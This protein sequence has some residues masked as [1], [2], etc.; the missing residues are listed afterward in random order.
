MKNLLSI[1]VLFLFACAQAKPP[2][3]RLAQLVGLLLVA[4]CA[5]LS[6]ASC[7]RPKSTSV[8]QQVGSLPII[9]MHLHAHRLADYGGG[10]P[11]CAN[12]QEILYA[13]VDPREPTAPASSPQ[14][15]TCASPV[16]APSNDDA[17]MRQTLAL[18]ERYNIFA[19]TTGS[20]DRVRAWHA[21]SPDR[22]IPAHAFADPGSEGVGEFRGLLRNHELAV[23][24]EV[25]PQYLGLS[26]DDPSLEPYFALAEEFDIPIG[27]HLG[28]GPYGGPYGPFPKYR[29]RLTS[30]FQVEDVLTRHPKLRLYVM[31][32]GSPLVD[33]M[34][35]VMYAHPQ[36]YVDI[37]GNDWQFP[38]EHFYG[39]LKKLVDAGLGKRIMWGSDQMVW[40]R[41]IEIAIATIENAPFLTTEQRRDVFYNNAA[42]FL[43][44]SEEQMAK[45]RRR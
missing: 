26:L 31:H 9:D 16:P 3:V 29:A 36:V 44:L 39:Q 27:A 5:L 11:V 43:R 24:A 10:M 17:V 4:G 32:Y 42:R 18:L 19:V 2:T 40:P 34:I 1:P 21:A 35:A 37:A 25:S 45:H 15:K 14:I 8:S 33:E 41:T 22:I 28:E 20:L 30:P 38:R 6:A 12:N 7:T 13:G 23:L